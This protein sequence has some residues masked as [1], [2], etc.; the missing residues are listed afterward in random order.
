MVL[1]DSINDLQAGGT[2]SHALVEVAL[3]ISLFSILI[4]FW[5]RKAQDMSQVIERATLREAEL[6]KEA[7]EWQRKVQSF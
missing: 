3:V 2:R 6:K 5:M 7:L 1:V 4:W